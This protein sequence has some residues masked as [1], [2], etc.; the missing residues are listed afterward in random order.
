VLAYRA[1]DAKVF[2]ESEL[3]RLL[4]RRLRE[5]DIPLPVWQAALPWRPTLPNQRRA[6]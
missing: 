1:A 4:R 3:E 2:S 6:A 5:R